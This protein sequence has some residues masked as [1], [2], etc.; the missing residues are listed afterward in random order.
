MKKLVLGLTLLTA[1]PTFATDFCKV[2]NNP[3]R[4][5]FVSC[6]GQ[7]TLVKTERGQQTTEMESRVVQEKLNEGY[8]IVGSSFS[9]NLSIILLTRD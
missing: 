8:K 5:V 6:N 3:L 1:L 2:L 4:G 7:Q 9:G